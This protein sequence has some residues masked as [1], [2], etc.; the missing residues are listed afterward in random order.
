MNEIE[1]L[2]FYAPNHYLDE[3]TLEYNKIFNESKTKKQIKRCLEY[4]KIPRLLYNKL[5]NLHCRPVYTEEMFN[6]LRINRNNY[7]HIRTLYEKFCKV[8]NIVPK[9]HGFRTTLTRK[10]IIDTTRSLHKYTKEEE[11]W[12]INNYINYI[13]DEIFI[14]N[15]LTK[16]FNTKFNTNIKTSYISNKLKTLKIDRPKAYSFYERTPIGHEWTY[17]RDNIV[18]IKVSRKPCKP[19]DNPIVLNYRKKAHVMYEQYHNIKINDN[20]Q[21][22]I[23]LDNNKFNFDKN[24]LYLIN[25]K[26]YRSYLSSGYNNQTLETKLNALKV[27]EIQ[28][29]IKEIE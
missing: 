26:A 8:F 14:I 12:L 4:R 22:V 2:Q 3:I 10:G 21:I 11:Q 13:E 5:D 23:H 19:T 15:K 16:D 20:D 6:W 28:Q 1:W 9:Y 18:Y 25:R 27:S 29:L 7:K 17:K 24:N